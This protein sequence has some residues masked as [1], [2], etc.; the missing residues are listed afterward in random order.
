MVSKYEHRTSVFKA[1]PFL[2][3]YVARATTSN[4]LME[5]SLILENNSFTL[6][7]DKESLTFW[8]IN[9]TI[10]HF[11]SCSTFENCNLIDSGICS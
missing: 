3:R 2:E 5:T 11:S 10:E 6:S 1:E 9:S 8:L 7:S 4:P